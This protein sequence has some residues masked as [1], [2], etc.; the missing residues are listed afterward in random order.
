MGN[1]NVKI[2]G[3]RV[4]NTVT[5]RKETV[6]TPS[7]HPSK[8]STQAALLPPLIAMPQVASAS[9]WMLASSAI[10]SAML[11]GCFLKSLSVFAE[12]SPII[13]AIRTFLLD[14]RVF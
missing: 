13:Q 6:S 8:P 2:E 11:A 1:L 5:R 12:D 7:P 9:L 3:R 14:G 4:S 10:Q